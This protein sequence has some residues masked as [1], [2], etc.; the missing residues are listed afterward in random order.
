MD[1]RLMVK[2]KC[3]VKEIWNR[4]HDILCEKKGNM[5]P[6]TVAV[7]IV[8]MIMLLVASEYMKLMILCSGIEDSFEE[9]IISVV[10][11]NYNEVYHCVRE[12]YA[13]G[14]EPNGEESFYSSIDVGDVEGR[15]AGLLGLTTVSGLYQK[16]ASDGNMEY[17]ISDVQVSVHNAPMVR[18]GEKFYA[19]GSLVLTIPVRFA[20][21]R[22]AVLPVNIHVKAS[23]DEK[24]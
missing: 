12:G 5:F 3:H 1:F 9:A 22:I 24:F 10:N 11:D 6:F 7:A 18:S 19:A 21:K 8:L 20:G 23:L 16:D 15:L 4:G 2:R 13:A 14:Y 17:T